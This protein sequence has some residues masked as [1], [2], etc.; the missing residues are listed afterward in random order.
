MLALT[1]TM[2]TGQFSGSVGK[3]DLDLKI[4]GGRAGGWFKGHYIDLALKIESSGN[5]YLNGPV[6]QGYVLWRGYGNLV[7][8]SQSCIP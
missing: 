1:G 2:G 4:F 3:D 6:N 8:D 5:F 7:I